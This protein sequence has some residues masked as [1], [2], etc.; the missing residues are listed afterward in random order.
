MV[1][2]KRLDFVLRIAD[3][4]LWIADGGSSQE[5]R[6]IVKSCQKWS[7]IVE[8]CTPTNHSLVLFALHFSFLIG[9]WCLWGSHKGIA[10]QQAVAGET[11]YPL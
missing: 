11:S 9:L 1:N 8:S 2:D 4:G 5:L 3:G 10:G 7:R 6:R